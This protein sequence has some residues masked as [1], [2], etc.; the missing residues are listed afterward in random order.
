MHWI[1]S[2]LNVSFNNAVNSGRTGL[3]HA[4]SEWGGWVDVTLVKPGSF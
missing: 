4:L 1:H 3:F 2:T